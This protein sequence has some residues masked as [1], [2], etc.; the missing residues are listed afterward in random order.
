VSTVQQT[1][2][3]DVPLRT[4]YDQ[5]TQ[6]ESFPR[7]MEGVEEVE[8]RTERLTHWRTRIAG[9]SREFDAEIIEQQPDRRIAWQ[10]IEGPQQ[11][12][13]VAFERLDDAHTRLV[14][15]MDFEPEGM[16]EQVGDRLGIVERRVRGDLERF[17][18]F[19]ES[20]GTQT[21]GWR[22]EVHQPDGGT[23]V[24]VGR[25][26][27]DRTA[28]GAPAA[29]A[30]AA[31]AGG[32]PDEDPPE[33]VMPGPGARTERDVDSGLT[34]PA[35]VPPGTNVPPEPLDPRVQD[36]RPITGRPNDLI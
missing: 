7:F 3:V 4:A 29:G 6:F 25:E 34:G 12:G 10:A 11:R 14:L 19:I 28:A 35:V 17:K 30:A 23:D 27:P 16:V 15:Q 21:G 5:W 8:Q 2:D 24:A 32:R 36:D 9:V 26:A 1:I 20:R 18:E 31:P 13:V 22:G 33:P